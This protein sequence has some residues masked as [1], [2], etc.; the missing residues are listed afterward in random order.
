[1]SLQLLLTKRNILWLILL[2]I[3]F[4]PML[5]ISIIIWI[6]SQLTKNQN[7]GDNHILPANA[8]KRVLITGSDTL[9]GKPKNFGQNGV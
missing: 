1:M 6:Y 4:W 7:V 8:Q 2:W 3:S 5:L 9:Q